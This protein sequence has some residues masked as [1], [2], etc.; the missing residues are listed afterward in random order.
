LDNFPNQTEEEFVDANHTSVN[1]FEM[2][3]E[4]LLTSDLDVEPV[5]TNNNNL[6]GMNARENDDDDFSDEDLLA[7]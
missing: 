5:E 4:E 3:D 7:D 2:D 6:N 1:S